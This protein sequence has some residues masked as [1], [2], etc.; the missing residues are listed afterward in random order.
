MILGA[1][2]EPVLGAAP[3]RHVPAHDHD[4]PPECCFVHAFVAVRDLRT[5]VG[6]ACLHLLKA[7]IGSGTE[8]PCVPGTSGSMR[9]AVFEIRS[10]VCQ[11]LTFPDLVQLREGRSRNRTRRHSNAAI[12]LLDLWRHNEVERVKL[13][14]RVAALD[15]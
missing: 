5:T 4:R 6:H 3:G 10:Q 7:R 15:C 14:T 11:F 12:N 13:Q 2:R 8:I 9:L 1:T